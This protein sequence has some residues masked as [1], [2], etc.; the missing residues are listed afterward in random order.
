MLCEKELFP[1]LG[2]RPI[3]E[4]TAPE[5]LTVLRKIEARGALEMLKKSMQLAGQVFRFGVATGRAERDPT[6]DLKGTLKTRKAKHM[7]RI[8]EAEL[9]ELMRKISAYDDEFQKRLALQFLALTFVRTG[10]MGFAEWPEIDKAKDEWRIPAE[11][12]KMLS[13]HIGPLSTQALDVIRQ[14]RELTGRGGG[15]SQASRT[16]R[17]PSART[18]CCSPYTGWYITLE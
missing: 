7:A 13:P 9:P 5:L 16:R 12:I 14:L 1:A 17:S 18:R 6:P 4:I 2:A 11:K 8:T 10:E 3:A 15:Y